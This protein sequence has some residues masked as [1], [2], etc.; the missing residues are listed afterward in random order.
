MYQSQWTAGVPTIALQEKRDH[1]SDK[2]T[3]LKLMIDLAGVSP[4]EVRRVQVLS[5]FK[6]KLR[7]ILNLDMIGMIDTVVETPNGAGKVTIDGE[8]KFYQDEA[9]LVDNVRRTLFDVDPLMSEYESRSLN[10][11]IDNY[12]SQKGKWPPSFLRLCFYRKT[13]LRLPIPCLALCITAQ[14]F[15]RG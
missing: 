1:N 3:D 7:Q 10:G 5:T 15:D 4:S 13:G 11:I 2:M 9:I 6:Y 8:L 12:Q 14:D